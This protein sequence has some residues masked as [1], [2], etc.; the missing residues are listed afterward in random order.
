MQ[1]RP[2][3]LSQS[4]STKVSAKSNA[5]STNA[6]SLASKNC[7]SV[8][9]YF[10]NLSYIQMALQEQN[11]PDLAHTVFNRKRRINFWKKIY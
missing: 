11:S 2:K 7:W 3:N 10:Q 9:Q 8:L 4:T 5:K 6:S 1:L